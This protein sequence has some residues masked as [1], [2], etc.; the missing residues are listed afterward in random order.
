[1]EILPFEG[2]SQPNELSSHYK[3]S[4]PSQKY[5]TPQEMTNLM[6]VG[7]GRPPSGTK[8]RQQE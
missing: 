5:F 2:Q 7:K 4:L 8:N 1:M 3:G 6:R